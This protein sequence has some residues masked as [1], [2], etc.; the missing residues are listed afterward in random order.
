MLRTV[1][2]KTVIEVSRQ[3][4]CPHLKKVL[5]DCLKTSLTNY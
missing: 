3:P 2:F 4:I 1:D 5:I